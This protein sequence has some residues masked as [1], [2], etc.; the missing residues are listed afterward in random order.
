MSMS[1]N[2]LIKFTTFW[3]L[4]GYT[5][6]IILRPSR[7]SRYEHNV[8]QPKMSDYLHT[9]C[10]VVLAGLSEGIERLILWSLYHIT[11]WYLC[12]II[13]SPLYHIILSP[14][15]HIILWYLCH[16]ILWSLYNLTLWYL[17]HITLSPL[18]HITLPGL[19]NLELFT[20]V[21]PQ[22]LQ[23]TYMFRTIDQNTVLRI[24][25]I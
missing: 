6:T 5:A 8:I 20:P 23:L 19:W 12:H 16:I 14:L 1:W 17:C 13:L 2:S 24:I 4:S 18:C 21:V 11:L 15:C 3:T 22:V 9:T 10:M 7:E 25:W